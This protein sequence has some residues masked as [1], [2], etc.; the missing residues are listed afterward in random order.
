L[1]ISFSARN[2]LLDY[3]PRR[4]IFAKFHIFFEDIFQVSRSASVELTAYRLVNLEKGGPMK[5]DVIGSNEVSA[6]VAGNNQARHSSGLHGA[7][8]VMPQS[9]QA[10]NLTER[11]A[12]SP[13]P[14]RTVTYNATGTLNK[15]SIAGATIDEVIS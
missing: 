9:V 15:I 11:S 14:S 12:A 4:Y 8:L 13:K 5:I 6:V 2:F 3:F 10:V 7:Q 1:R